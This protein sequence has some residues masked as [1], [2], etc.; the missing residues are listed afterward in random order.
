MPMVDGDWSV[1]RATGNI[2]YIGFDHS[3]TTTVAAGA[4]VTGDYY[5]IRSVGTTDFTLVG[6]ANNN[7]GT[8]FEA[9]GAGTGTGVATQASSYA[10]VIQFHRWLQALA[11]DPEFAGDDELDIIDKDPSARSTDNIITLT[12]GFNV[13]ATEIEHLYDGSVTQGSGPTEE[14]WDGI[15]NFGNKSVHIQVHQNGAILTDDYWNYGWQAGSHSGGTSATVLT[16]TTASFTTDEWVG[17][18]I[19]NVTDGSRGIITANT[20]TTITVDELYGGTSNDFVAADVYNIA[21]PLNGDSGAGISHRFMI[22]VRE[23]GVD[24]GRRRLLGTSRRYGNTFSEFSINGANPG[25]NVLALSDSADLNNTTAPSVIDAIA[26]IT[27]TEGLRLIDISGDG[28]TEE[29]YSQWDLGAQS[30]NTFYEYMKWLSADSNPNGTNLQGES[31]ELH[32]GVTHS[33]PYDAENG[34][35]TTATNDKHVFG[36]YI[37]HGAVT[38]GPFTVGEAVH[39]DTATPVW[40]G[41]VLAVDTVNTSLIVDVESGTVGT[42]SFTGQTSGAQA[43]VSVAPTGV[44]IQNAAGEL[45]VL[46]FDDDGTSGNFYGQLTKGVAPLDNTR[47]YDATDHT[48]SY[49]LSANAT[50]RPVSAPFVGVST[51]SALIGAYGLGV[52]A[53]DAAAADTY[54]DLQNTPVN[55]P[56]NVTFTVSGFETGDYVLCTENN[57]S[58][59]NFTQMALNATLSGATVTSVPINPAPGVPTDTPTTAGTKGSIRIERNNGLYSLHRYT[60]FDAG[61]DTFTIPSTDFSTNNATSGNNV[62]IGYLD[63]VATGSSDTF[64]Y[65]YSSDRSHFV[66]VRD[67]GVT[68]IKTAE[69][70]GSMTSTGG[71]ASVNRID[72]T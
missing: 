17:Y 16:D 56:N 28:S 35:P 66:R 19:I 57:A 27:N 32:R 1:D 40:K 29:Y 64:S 10:T 21:V 8:R 24:I 65:V 62:F 63:Y 22:K 47:V 71:T 53:D 6:A 15:V 7:V 18:T 34:A 14:R 3:P 69:G 44:E 37:N 50:E 58:D 20:S 72:D 38:G 2:R 51:G 11:D 5:Q 70:T 43:T 67:G 30:K 52:N 31:G 68:P 13:T 49:D 59:I 54:F 4:F 26:D 55:P 33:V 9:T 39:E 48:D 41:R 46:A 23:D 60:A 36:T 12:N 61:A 25:N 42:E 45:K